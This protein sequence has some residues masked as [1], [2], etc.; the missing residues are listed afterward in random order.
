MP[1]FLVTNGKTFEPFSFE[2][3]VKPLA[4]TQERH[5]AAQDAYDKLSMDTESLANY[6][7]DNEDDKEAK[8]MYESYRDKLKTLQDNLWQYGVT[9]Q[10]R[11]DLAAARIGY[12]KD[13]QRLGKAIE[14]RQARSKEYWDLAHKNPDLIVGNDPRLYGLDNYLKDDTFGSNWFSYSGN[15]FMSE[16]GADAKARALELRRNIVNEDEVPGYITRIEQ[17]GFTQDEVD[18]AILAARSGAYKYIED[19]PIKILAETLIDHINATGAVLGKNISKEQYNRFFDYAKPALSQGILGVDTKDFVDKGYQAVVGGRG[20]ADID[21]NGGYIPM[22]GI[23]VVN[24]TPEPLRSSDYGDYADFFDKHNKKYKDGKT[25]E[26]ILPDGTTAIA[27]DFIDATNYIYESQARKDGRLRFGADIALPGENFWGTNSSKQEI[28]KPEKNTGKIVKLI[29]GDISNKDIKEIGLDNF[30]IEE[31]LD[32][33]KDFVGLY[34]DDS[35]KHLNIEATK[36]FNLLRLAHMKHVKDIQE[37][38][39]NIK[40]SEYAINPEN[41]REMRK[42]F[43]NG[44]PQNIPFAD[45]M[46]MISTKN[47]IK[48]ATP[49]TLISS[50]S[51]DDFARG[52][53][54]RKMIDV[55][56]KQVASENSG[57]DSLKKGSPYAIEVLD[58]G[59]MSSGSTILDLGQIFQKDE[60]GNSI[61]TGSLSSVEFNPYDIASAPKNPRF[62]FTSNQSIGK[63]YRADIGYLGDYIKNALLYKAYN[64]MSKYSDE[65][66]GVITPAD[67]IAYMMQPLTEPEKFYQMNETKAKEWYNNTLAYL[68]FAK[69]DNFNPRN[70]IRDESSRKQLYEA[71]VNYTNAFLTKVLNTYNNA[72]PTHTGLSSS[73]MAGAR[74]V[75]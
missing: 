59:L 52:N 54:A 42:K 57:G 18:K 49:S 62:R 64:G 39:P 3:L 43:N 68:G 8:A 40:L 35:K 65:P 58:S 1:R 51:S 34:Q 47:F 45:A 46:N 27:E 71:I 69:D 23:P 41:E 61:R 10:T 15:Q 14:A 33:F 75:E 25:L 67:A 6:I 7:S 28:F 16:V 26:L 12:A 44:I 11:R 19:G 9:A 20:G 4:Y 13:I 37:K 73:K 2:E 22:S 63:V 70:F 21:S 55:F 53:F 60:K 50:D 32:G 66:N 72:H 38:N 30:A 17:R 24:T 29:T 56:S 31:G 36:E 5:D 48:R 74:V